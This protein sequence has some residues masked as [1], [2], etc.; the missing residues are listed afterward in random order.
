M[1]WFVK[2]H[3][4]KGTAAVY[5]ACILIIW[6]PALS[7]AAAVVALCFAWREFKSSFR[8]L[9]EADAEQSEA[10]SFDA[11]AAITASVVLADPSPVIVNN[12]IPTGNEASADWLRLPA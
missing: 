5:V 8:Q 9:D 4:G 6:P 7:W 3:A 10:D 12:R 11:A 1:K 2:S